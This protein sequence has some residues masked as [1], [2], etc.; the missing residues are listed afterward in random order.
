MARITTITFT[1]DYRAVVEDVASMLKNPV[2][3]ER[4]EGNHAV[5][6]VEGDF[7]TFVISDM[8]MWGGHF[9]FEI[10]DNHILD[11]DDRQSRALLSEYQPGMG[12]VLFAPTIALV[13]RRRLIE[14]RTQTVTEKY[15]D[16]QIISRNKSEWEIHRADEWEEITQ[17]WGQKVPR[18]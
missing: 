9:K 3:T 5:V 15:R 14:T 8:D 10:C 4:T 18:Q 11:E 13:Y 7:E 2:I 17:E 6:D 16:D 12:A 1:K